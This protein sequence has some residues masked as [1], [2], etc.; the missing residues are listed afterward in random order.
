M[1]VACSLHPSTLVLVGQGWV[2]FLQV[3]GQPCESELSGQYLPGV[4][5]ALAVQVAWVLQP[6]CG[7]WYIIVPSHRSSK[8]GSHVTGQELASQMAPL[9]LLG[10]NIH[11]SSSKQPSPISLPAQNSYSSSH[12]N[13]HFCTSQYFP[14]LST[15]LGSHVGACG[16][17]LIGGVVQA[18]C[19]SESHS[20]GQ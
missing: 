1:H 17:P 14:L 18:C 19:V 12:V 13:V 7:P 15:W 4:L 6:A 11:T 3:I 10:F 2:S 9:S 20:T 16:H 5:C 8:V